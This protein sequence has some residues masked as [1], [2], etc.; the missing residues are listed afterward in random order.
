MSAAEDIAAT[1]RPRLPR[2]VR[3]SRDEARGGFVLLAPERVVRADPVAAAVLERCD[4]ARTLAE[5]VD[6]LCATYRGERGRIEADV[7]RLLADLSA[8]KMVEL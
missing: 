6:D 1:A 7:R 2:G 4:G 8:K 5:I 3:L